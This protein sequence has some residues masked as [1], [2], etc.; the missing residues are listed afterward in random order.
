MEKQ[1]L[2]NAKCNNCGYGGLFGSRIVIEFGKT[3]LEV[4]CPNCGTP[5]L[6]IHN[7]Y[8]ANAQAIQDGQVG[9]M[10]FVVRDL[11]GRFVKT[12]AEKR[13]VPQTYR[14]T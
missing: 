9:T 7:G 2:T 10:E 6:T 11:K 1:Y 8:M 14:V 3:L 12:K 4:P 5:N 13:T